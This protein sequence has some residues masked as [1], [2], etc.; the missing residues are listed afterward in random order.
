MI[1][2]FSTI[3]VSCRSRL[4]KINEQLTS[5]EQR[6]EYIEAR[7]SNDKYFFNN[8]NNNEEED[9]LFIYLQYYLQDKIS[10]NSN[11]NLQRIN[12]HHD[13]CGGYFI[14]YR[15]SE[16]SIQYLSVEFDILT[17]NKSIMVIIKT[18]KKFLRF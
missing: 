4:A 16:K 14:I 8:N 9:P 10:I 12:V 1:I 7:V 18:I 5:L 2:Y 11:K 3:D 13:Y 17:I 6:V 15:L